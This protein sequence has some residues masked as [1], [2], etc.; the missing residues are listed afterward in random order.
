MLA[1]AKTQ[2]A[3]AVENG[4]LTQTRSDEILARLT[5]GAKRLVQRVPAK[6]Q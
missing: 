3:K 5:D 2:L 1:P 4:H 6:H